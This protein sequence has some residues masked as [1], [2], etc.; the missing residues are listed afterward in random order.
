MTEGHICDLV[1]AAAANAGF[2][3]KCCY[4]NNTVLVGFR[5]ADHSVLDHLTQSAETSMTYPS[6][7]LEGLKTGDRV[8][9]GTGRYQVR[10]VVTIADGSEMRATL[11]LLGRNYR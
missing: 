6:G 10:E 7:A 1:Y 11:T 3:R 8:E 9:V 2:L 5:T 4:R